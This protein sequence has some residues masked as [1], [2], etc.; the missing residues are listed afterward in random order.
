M[1]SGEAE[2]LNVPKTWHLLAKYLDFESW[3][4]A[5][6]IKLDSIDE[7]LFGSKI[8]TEVGLPA[9]S[10]VAKLYKPPSVAQFKLTMAF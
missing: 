9:E 8:G 5:L 6:G 3:S 2:Q 10:R 4:R 7:A 1:L